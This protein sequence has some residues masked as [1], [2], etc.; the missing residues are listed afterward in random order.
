MFEN[1]YVIIRTF[2]AGVHVGTLKSRGGTEV[3]LNNARRLWY[4]EGAFTLNA[5][6]TDGIHRGKLSPTVPE[7]L[8]TQAIEIIPTSSQAESQLKAM[9]AHKP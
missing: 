5:V 8:L 4:W 9:E 2:S 1:Q 3:V 7:I 6:A